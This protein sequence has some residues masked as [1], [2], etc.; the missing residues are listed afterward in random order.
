MAFVRHVPHRCGDVH[1]RWPRLFL[2]T[3]GF[4]FTKASCRV[5]PLWTE[6]RSPEALQQPRDAERRR[7]GELSHSVKSLWLSPTQK[8]ANQ[9][10][11]VQRPSLKLGTCQP[12]LLAK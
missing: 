12:R 11:E 4:G 9:V 8:Y 1:S 5:P 7:Y 6:L 2:L 3:A 10:D